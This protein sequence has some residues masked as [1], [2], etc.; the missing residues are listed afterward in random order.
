MRLRFTKM[1]GAGNDFVMLDGVS[2]KL[3]KLS[4][5]K[6]RHIAD[7]HFGI[8][9]DQLLIAE[10]PETPDVDFRYRIYN[11]DGKEVEN[12]GNGSRCFAIFVRQRG[13]T[14]KT[15]MTVETAGGNLVLNVNPDNTVSV[16]MGIPVLEPQA[17]PFMA[18]N[19]AVSY[20]LDVEGE[21][22]EI[23]AVSMG[24]PHAVVMVEN[25][26]AFPV[27]RIG[28]SIETHE[29]FPARV[30]AGFLQP[31]SSSEASL[32]VFERGVGETLACGTG[33]CAAMVSGRLRNIF[34]AQVTMH[35]PG[36]SLQLT[37][38]GVGKPVIMTGPAVSVFQGQINI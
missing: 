4:A 12:C 5:E 21:T 32:R 17:I 38:E 22:F 8:G 15:R 33:A 2:Q 23:S 35:L 14:Q 1:H 10:P 11:Q 30:N 9:C 6:I 13:L 19:Q 25:L 27:T 20:S 24:N 37:W 36:G 31:L 28:K 7:R 16:N 29:R 18:D 26:D 34:D 3:P